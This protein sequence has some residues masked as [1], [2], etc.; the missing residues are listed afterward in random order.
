MA[1]GKE[2]EFMESLNLI[3]RGRE[4]PVKIF[5]KESNV[6]R[7]EFQSYPVDDMERKLLCESRQLSDF[8]TIFFDPRVRVSL[9]HLLCGGHKTTSKTNHDY[10]PL[11][12]WFQWA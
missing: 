6:I 7:L 3:F 11:S 1:D 5:E 9:Q 12:F 10:R 2:N 4:E 8:L